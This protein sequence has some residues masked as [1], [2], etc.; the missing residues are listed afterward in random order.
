MT[1]QTGLYVQNLADGSGATARG[2]RLAMG[3]LLAKNTDGTVKVGVLAD[4]QGPV[5]TGTSG[6]SY[7]IRTHVAVTKMSDANGATLVP[8]YGT[9]NVATDPAPGSNSRIDI[10]YVLQRHL[11]VDGGSDVVNTPIFGVAKGNAASSP[12]PPSIP[13][14]ALELARVPVTV[15]TTATSGL[16]FTQGAITTANAGSQHQF[17]G[18]R[19][20]VDYDASKH[21][22]K[23]LTWQTA[24]ST[25]TNGIAPVVANLSTYFTG[26]ASVQLTGSGDDPLRSPKAIITGNA[27][28][29][30]C[31]GANGSGLIS[32]AVSMD[33]TIVGWV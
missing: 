21:A 19:W 7:N 20:G 9:V 13:T 5:V 14:G 29:A 26:V 8:N 23:T 16:T 24:P 22:V 28:N 11:T 30:Y 25:D 17:L 32:T 4:G 31:Y 18:K 6:M 15:N 3:G 33:V 10:I 12:Q 27:L 2:S 1:A